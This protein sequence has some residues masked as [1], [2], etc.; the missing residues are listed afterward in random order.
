M[1]TIPSLPPLVTRTNG[2]AD[3]I[4]A[5]RLANSLLTASD[6][7][8]LT[9]RRTDLFERVKLLWLFTAVCLAGDATWL[10]TDRELRDEPTLLRMGTYSILQCMV[11]V[12]VF[13]SIFGF[14][15]VKKLD[16]KRIEQANGRLRECWLLLTAEE[17]NLIK[18]ALVAYKDKQFSSFREQHAA[19]KM[20]LSI[21]S[22]SLKHPKRSIPQIEQLIASLQVESPV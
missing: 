17:K 2:S 22:A 14:V 5:A 20:T 9:V 4:L 19:W 21:I 18:E 8:E 10:A 13:F 6:L 16:T 7:N 11:V 3:A 12:L 15:N 1:S